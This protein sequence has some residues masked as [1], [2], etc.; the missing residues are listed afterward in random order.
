MK[1]VAEIVGVSAQTVSAVINNKPGITD[2]TRARVLEPI[3]QLGYRPYS[4][5]LP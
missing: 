1:D 2:E 4:V 3:Q 5:A